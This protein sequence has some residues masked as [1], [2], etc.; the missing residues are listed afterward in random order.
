MVGVRGLPAARAA[1]PVQAAPCASGRDPAA[2]A[3][4]A[5]RSQPPGGG[6]GRS[7]PRRRRAAAAAAAAA[8]GTNGPGAAA[9]AEAQAEAAPITGFKVAVF[10]AQPYVE[11]F[12]EGPL[13]AAIAD[14]DAQLRVRTTE[15]GEGAAAA[16]RLNRH[17]ARRG[18][19]AAGQA[20][21]LCAAA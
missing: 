3:A 1:R 21:G 19:G 7:Q 6:G 18:Q 5:C 8:A 11:E 20:A 15:G 10:S 16:A 4:A 17:G 14:P 9:A 13:K 12:L 2:A